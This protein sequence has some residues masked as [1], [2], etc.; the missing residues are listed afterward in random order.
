MSVLHF[1]FTVVITKGII[2]PVAR[3]CLCRCSGSLQSRDSLA[4]FLLHLFLR[5]VLGFFRLWIV[6]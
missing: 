2:Q 6:S 5:R 1:H 3:P 4:G